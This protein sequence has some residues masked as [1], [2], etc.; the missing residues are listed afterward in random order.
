M[1][2]TYDNIRWE[3]DAL[4]T[5]YT[6]HWSHFRHAIDKSYQAFNIHMVMMALL[7]SAISLA[8]DQDSS[9]IALPL[10]MVIGVVAFASSIGTIS[11]L[12]TQRTGYVWHQKVIDVLR[13]RLSK[14]TS[15]IL[16]PEVDLFYDRKIF[17]PG[18]AWFGRVNF[19]VLTGSSVVVLCAYLIFS[20]LSSTGIGIALD[21][22]TSLFLSLYIFALSLQ[23]M[24]HS[25]IS[26]SQS[27][28]R[29]LYCQMRK[30]EHPPTESRDIKYIRLYSKY[31]LA[32]EG[33][34][35]ICAIPLLFM[36]SLT[37][38][39]LSVNIFVLLI[40]ILCLL[41]TGKEIVC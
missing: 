38:I 20:G 35:I 18:T 2:D 15:D 14:K 36:S 23:L 37:L 11:T 33:I 12:V 1:S 10:F 3:L 30:Y 9:S 34:T 24:Y 7:F 8:N 39:L 21:S 22:Y 6:Q 27:R 17:S 26:Q 29:E 19:V 4:K 41:K 16:Q 40:T 28:A 13:E 5:E 31:L 25:V 32:F